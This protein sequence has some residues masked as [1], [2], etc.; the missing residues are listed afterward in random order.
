MLRIPEIH[1][2][3]IECGDAM[4]EVI[5]SVINF[6]GAME[7]ISAAS[8]AQDGE[9]SWQWG[10]EDDYVWGKLL[11]RLLTALRQKRLHE[12]PEDSV[13]RARRRFDILQEVVEPPP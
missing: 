8:D 3:D 7:T 2:T 1:S 12:K 4:L 11:Q 9:E 6:A 5:A 13:R 10:P